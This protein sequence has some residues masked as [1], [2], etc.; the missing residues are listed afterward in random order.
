MRIWSPK[1]RATFPANGAFG[2]TPGPNSRHSPERRTVTGRV[3][4]WGVKTG[5]A[6]DQPGDVLGRFGAATKAWF[7]AAFAHPT[8]P[9]QLGWPAIAL[10]DS[11]LIS[12]V[13]WNGIQTVPPGESGTQPAA[14]V[15]R[16]R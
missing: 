13:P 9:Q 3:Q 12:R 6:A 11:T 7:A 8:R 16:R 10:G 15:S 14:R 5:S 2:T 4:Y 1:A